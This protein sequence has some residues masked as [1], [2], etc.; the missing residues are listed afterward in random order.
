MERNIPYMTHHLIRKIPLLGLFCLLFLLGSCQND[1]TQNENGK[2]IPGK[3][4]LDFKSYK[5]MSLALPSGKLINAFL[6]KGPQQQTQ[7]LS[8]VRPEEL[9]DNE[10]M[11]FWYPE[12]GP[13]SFWMPNTYINLDIIFLNEDFKVLYVAKNVLA[14]PGMEE[15]P[16]IART[17]SIFARHVLEL[18]SSSPLTD[19]IK[20][21]TSLRLIE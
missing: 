6:A 9:T 12:K 2:I 10:G 13:R 8:G 3:R 17:P 5:K 20:K 4:V 15:P 14:H 19:E 1:K 7:G 16:V 18:K 21:G 11:L